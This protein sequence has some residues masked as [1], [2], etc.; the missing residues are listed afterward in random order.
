MILLAAGPAIIFHTQHCNIIKLCGILYKCT[1]SFHYITE[2]ILWRCCRVFV[3]SLQHP[4]S[5]E[6]FLGGVFSF[7]NAVC[8]DKQAVSR[9]HLEFMLPEPYLFDH[10]DGRRMAVF[11]QLILSALAA[12]YRMFVAGVGSNAFS[13]GKIDDPKPDRNKHFRVIALQQLVIDFGQD[14]SRAVPVQD[15]VFDQYFCDHHKESR[16]HTL[17]GDIRHDHGHVLIIHQEEIIEISA[18]FLGRIHRSVD[19]KFPTVWKRGK[20]A[21]KLAGLN[22]G[23]HAEFG[24]DPL[25]FGSDLSD[26][27]HIVDCPPGKLGEGLRQYLHLVTGTEGVFHGEQ[28]IGP[29]Q[30][31][32][33]V[34]HD[35]QRPDDSLAQ[36]GSAYSPESEQDQKKDD[37]GP[38]GVRKALPVGYRRLG[39]NVLQFF[40]HHF[41]G[42]L[43]HFLVNNGY[44]SPSYRIETGPR[45][46]VLFSVYRDC[47]QVCRSAESIPDKGREFFVIRISQ[48]LC[49]ISRPDTENPFFLRRKDY[50]PFLVDDSDK[51]SFLTG[52]LNSFRQFFQEKVGSG[53]RRKL[54][55][56][57]DR[58]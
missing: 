26:L 42:D 1:D 49:G 17:T 31:G 4:V 5:T 54:P 36:N 58:N 14:N 34:C 55:V 18:Y 44:K 47:L 32:Y 38:R 51:S 35:G 10:T 9:L 43:G 3:Q 57:I 12:D 25:L 2:D 39:G 56:H 28:R 6:Q 27:L 16:R 29:A 30:G 7:R 15:A 50:M 24:S 23:R 8:I 11:Y 22:V 52:A 40:F 37:Q 46:I 53:D 33:L 21:W 19:F 20:N 41:L 13:G 48:I 45:H